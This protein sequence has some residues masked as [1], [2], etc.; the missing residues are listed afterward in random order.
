MLHAQLEQLMFV[1]EIMNGK[2]SFSQY[3]SILITNYLIT[4]D[5]EPRLL[6]KI[7][8]PAF[9]RLEI[10]KRLKLEA[11]L[12]DLGEVKINP[13][14]L[15][16]TTTNLSGSLHALGCL[17]VLEGATL[18]GNIIVQKL[19]ENP[20]LAPHKLDFNYYQVYGEEL[21]SYWKQFCDTINEQP[22]ENYDEIIEGAKF[23]YNA[24]IELRL[25]LAN[26]LIENHGNL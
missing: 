23:M 6:E 17:Y 15:K 25:L 7:D 4:A 3:Q 22:T 21:I 24:F 13:E 18:G 11:L 19:K 20:S 8:S 1:D 12:K 14:D 5:Y 26:K 9:L 16:S 2:L 10:H